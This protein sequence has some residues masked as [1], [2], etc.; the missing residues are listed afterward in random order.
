MT[1][2]ENTPVELT[3][4]RKTR[5]LIARELRTFGLLA[6]SERCHNPPPSDVDAEEKLLSEVL[7]G[8]L[9]PDWFDADHCMQPMIAA[10]IE[11]CAALRS[12]GQWPASDQ[13]LPIPQ[14]RAMLEKQKFNG[15]VVAAELLDIAHRCAAPLSLDDLCR[16]IRSLHY[17]RS[18]IVS[19]GELDALLRQPDAKPESIARARKHVDTALTEAAL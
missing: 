8:A 7:H 16:R 19:L 4:D 10:A 11:V 2:D 17:R 6:S 9:I 3:L 18:A 14:I 1:T 12:V 13:P 15:A 5:E